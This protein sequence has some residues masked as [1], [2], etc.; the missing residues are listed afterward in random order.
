MEDKEKPVEG[1]LMDNEPNKGGRPSIF[2]EKYIEELPKLM[3]KGLTDV[4]IC[5]EWNISRD[6]FYRWKREK[7]E[8]A[9]A[10]DRGLVQCESW[11][12]NVGQA[13]MMGSIKG[14]KEKMWSNIM[15]NKFG[16]NRDFSEGG[17]NQTINIQNNYINKLSDEDLERQIKQLYEKAGIE[18]DKE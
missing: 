17:G 9:K 16:W 5:A 2:T 14:F 8:F 13:A 1:E 3:S 12:M 7:P 15:Q 4:Q 10:F 11:Y 18:H 6:T